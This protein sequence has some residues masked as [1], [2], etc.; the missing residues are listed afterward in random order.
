VDKT[1]GGK[2]KKQSSGLRAVE[3]VAADQL[4]LL[5]KDGVSLAISAQNISEVLSGLTKY[6][7]YNWYEAHLW[8]F[9]IV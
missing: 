6:D 8:E 4:S 7:Y 1:F 5:Y 2:G 9:T 3:T